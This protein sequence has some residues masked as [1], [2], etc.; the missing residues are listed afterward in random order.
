MPK[1]HSSAIVETDAIGEGVTIGEFS[2]VRP[3]AILGDGVTIHS[4][5]VVEANAEI[6]AGTEV[7]HGALIGRRPRAVGVISR[8]PTF[9]EELR[10]GCRCSIGANAI[11]YYGVEIGDDTLIGDAAALR[12]TSRIG[13]GCV[14]G[15]AVAVGRGTQIGDGS[16]VGYASLVTGKTRV[17]KNVFIAPGVI[18]TDDNAMGAEGWVEK[19]ARESVIEDEVRIGANATLLPEVT[20]GRGATVGAGSVVTRDVEPGVT[21]YGNP[22]RPA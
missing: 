4:H 5:S 20:I 8:E 21:A 13:N 9:R 7:L 19:E 16:W 11:L 10:V 17:G 15:R 22:A 18:T 12:E 2:I 14:I 3:G 6:G 1:I